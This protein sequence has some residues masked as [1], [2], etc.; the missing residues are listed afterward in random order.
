[1]VLTVS[2]DRMAGGFFLFIIL[3]CFVVVFSLPLCLSDSRRSL[4]LEDLNYFY[5]CQIGAADFHLP[6]FQSHLSHFVDKE[7]LTH[8]VNFDNY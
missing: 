8:A 6:T 5:F 2:V 1:M 4:L 3:F 7:K